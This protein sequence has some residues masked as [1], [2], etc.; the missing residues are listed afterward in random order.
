M[1]PGDSTPA[2]EVPDH[3]DDILLAATAVSKR[4]GGVRAVEDVSIAVRRGSIAAIIGPNGAGKT[5]L[6]NMISGFYRPD[7][8]AITFD[9]TDTTRFRPAQ[10]AALGIA[11]TFQNIALFGG[12]TV[13]D[14]LML[15]RHVR[16][17]SGILSCF[18]YWGLAQ[19]EE[20]AHR[21]RVE[22]L[23]DFLELQDLRK[24]PTSSLAY[25]LRK[26]VELGRALALDPKLLLL[27]EPMGGM[28]QEEKEDMARYIID[29]NEEWGTTII[30]I[31][32]DMAVVMDISDRVAVLDRGRKIAEGTPAEVQRNPE[33]IRAYLGT[34][35]R[36]AA[37]A[38]GGEQKGRAA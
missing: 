13:L 9:G 23:I 11:R 10:I 7:S 31:E 3:D 4:F 6:L 37:A 18:F 27:D 19:K 14:N 5:S 28:N 30:L 36:P 34:G 8:G 29:V 26:R 32:H 24:Q 15:G 2:G 17:K 12:M 33:V 16:M 35:E 21:A 1:A 25:G 22:E 20:V 38:A